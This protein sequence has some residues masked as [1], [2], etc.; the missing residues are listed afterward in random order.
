MS[1]EIS[2][3]EARAVAVQAH[4]MLVDVAGSEDG[5]AAL[6]AENARHA[7]PEVLLCLPAALACYP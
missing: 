1:Q 2:D 4:A 3:P 7:R 6:E 5:S